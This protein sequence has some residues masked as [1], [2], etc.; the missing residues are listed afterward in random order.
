MIKKYTLG[1]VLAFVILGASYSAWQ[2]S[3][4]VGGKTTVT[5]DPET[6][7]QLEKDKKAQEEYQKEIDAAPRR[8]PADPIKLVFV[9]PTSE[10]ERIDGN[11]EGMHKALLAEFKNDPL[12]VISN[13]DLPRGRNAMADDY[14]LI[15]LINEAKKGGKGGDAFV[16][17]QLGTEDAIGKDAKGKLVGVKALAYKAQMSSG[18]NYKPQEAKELGTIFQTQEMVN[19]LAVK[20]KAAV[21]NDIGPT[22]P[23]PESV[24]QIN[25]KYA[26]DNKTGKEGVQKIDATDLF[27]NL[28]KKKSK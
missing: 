3:V 14:K 27:K 7:A 20:I 13:V 12:L 5:G 8:K 2:K 4:T 17:V 15:A 24:N 22:L 25:G 19:K 21:K 1:F 23:A 10:K 18:Y 6:M 11:E 28:F 9:N 16:L 26:A